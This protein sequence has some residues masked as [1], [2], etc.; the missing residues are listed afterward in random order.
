MDPINLVT[1]DAEIPQTPQ[2]LKESHWITIL[3]MVV[4]ILLSLGAVVFLYHQNQQLKKMLV[5]YQAIPTPSTTTKPST[6]QKLYT[7]EEYRFSFRMP[8]GIGN[9]SLPEEKGVEF[10]GN[11]EGIDAARKNGVYGQFLPEITLSFIPK[12]KTYE[13]KST[14][15]ATEHVIK[16]AI[17]VDNRK[18][19]RYTVVS[20]DSRNYSS[21]I[22]SNIEIPIKDGY[23]LIEENNSSF[24]DG[25]N[26][27]LSTFKFTK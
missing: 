21:A 6:D 8:N 27:I 9:Y 26:Q 10:F 17:V 3:S 2:T 7:N 20:V 25:L 5:N 24:G 16:D 22:F 4:F 23:L 14:E 12:E 11:Q 13:A 18:S 15:V 19:I 1:G